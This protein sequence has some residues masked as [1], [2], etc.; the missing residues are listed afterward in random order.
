MRDYPQVEIYNGT[1]EEWPVEPATFDL[2]ISATAFHW[3][4]ESV[5]YPKVRQALKPSGTIVL[6][7]QKHV[8]IAA[9]EGFFGAVHEVYQQEAP[10]LAKEGY[11]QLPWSHEVDT[12]EKEAIDGT[13]LFKVVTVRRY[14]WNVTYDAEGYISLL[15][16][17]SDHIALDDDV[18]IRLFRGITDLIDMK[19]H[20]HIT[21]GYMSILYLAHCK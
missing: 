11:S 14:P 1:F 6:F 12:P 5:A 3:I 9:D 7:W 4:D 19:F 13:G 10:M 15:K 17:Y 18:R 20:G 8:R 21:K 2:I 16:T